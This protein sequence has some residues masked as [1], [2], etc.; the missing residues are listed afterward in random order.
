MTDHL[1]APSVLVDMLFLK[2]DVFA[3]DIDD[4]EESQAEVSQDACGCNG[5]CQSKL[6]KR[7][8]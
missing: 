1:D 4:D 3:L 7:D 2:D 5:L 8:T 6:L